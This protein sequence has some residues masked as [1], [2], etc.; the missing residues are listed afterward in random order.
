MPSQHLI[1]IGLPGK[2]SDLTTLLFPFLLVGP[3]APQSPPAGTFGTA[4]PEP[5]SMVVR[6]IGKVWQIHMQ[7]FQSSLIN[8]VKMVIWFVDR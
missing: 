3:A 6:A 4:V 2:V 1:L 8:Y 7:R 5:S